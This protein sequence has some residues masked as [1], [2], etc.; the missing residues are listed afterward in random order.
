VK[1][2]G[3][4]MTVTG[5]QFIRDWV[6][7]RA[8][9]VWDDRL[10]EMIRDADVFEL[11]WSQNSM[12]SPYVRREYEYALS[13]G[14]DNF[15]RPVF[16]E[17]PMPERK[18]DGL[19][20]PELARLH[21]QAID[22]G[23]APPRTITDEPA[24]MVIDGARTTPPPPPVASA[25]P[26]PTPMPSPAG[27]PPPA[28]RKRRGLVAAMG[29]LAA[30][31]V[32]IAALGTVALGTAATSHHGQTSSQTPPA[33][34]VITDASTD[35]HTV[36]VSSP[37]ETTHLTIVLTTTSDEP[38]FELQAEVTLDSIPFGTVPLVGGGSAGDEHRYAGTL[39]PF[40]HPGLATWRVNAG[41]GAQGSVTVDDC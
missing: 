41:G 10:L 32:G 38:P 35:Q 9:E 33:S 28:P 21:F 29:G 15:V 14:R 24:P 36:C 17:R 12:E 27:S 5:D 39:G 30:G 25:P 16:W 20:P 22:F 6:E 34:I 7:L 40:P 23:W 26:P 1:Q 8:G 37:P 3:R 11:F 31:L 2:F 13:L 4:F 19:P 18:A